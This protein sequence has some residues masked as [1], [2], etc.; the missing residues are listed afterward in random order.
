[1]KGA[2]AV[3]ELA[4]GAWLALGALIG[5]G[6]AHGWPVLALWVALWVVIPLLRQSR[7]RPVAAR[8]VVNREVIAYAEI[9]IWGQVFHC[10]HASHRALV[11]LKDGVCPL[12]AGKTPPEPEPAGGR[13]PVTPSSASRGG[14]LL[15]YETGW[16]QVAPR[17][18]EVTAFGDRERSYVVLPPETG[19]TPLISPPDYDG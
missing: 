4:A 9:Q 12:C 16:V 15:H 5:A 2:A 7:P 8:P 13:G 14:A 19:W 18:V 3:R 6:V 17:L 11:L 1:V 10:F